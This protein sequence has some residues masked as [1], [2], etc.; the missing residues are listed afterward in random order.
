[1]QLN[2]NDE[3]P[4]PFLDKLNLDKEKVIEAF[5]TPVNL[6]GIAAYVYSSLSSTSN[7]ATEKS[8]LDEMA[9]LYQSVSQAKKESTN[10]HGL[11]YN[12][13]HQE[14]LIEYKAIKS[15][16]DDMTK[17]DAEA[18]IEKHK[19]RSINGDNGVIFQNNDYNI[20]QMASVIADKKFEGIPVL[21]RH[22]ANDHTNDTQHYLTPL[23]VQSKFLTSI[24][25]NIEP[26]TLENFRSS[27]IIKQKTMN[28]SLIK[29]ENEVNEDVKFLREKGHNVLKEDVRSYVEFDR[30]Y[31]ITKNNQSITDSV[32]ISINRQKA[33]KL[34]TVIDNPE[35]LDYVKDIRLSEYK[36]DQVCAHIKSLYKRNDDSL[37]YFMSVNIESHVPYQLASIIKKDKRRN[38][39]DLQESILDESF[40]EPKRQKRFG[41]GR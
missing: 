38:D 20:A 9:S 15:L 36:N 14:S 32:D 6:A 17:S 4:I 39:P 12:H 30:L 10:K 2:R 29:Q 7:N 22:S 16:I 40:F 5:L 18:F 31:R 25:D 28:E 3:H 11:I 34:T 13:A 1:M 41:F 26:S 33:I 21:P 8:Y 35:L 24:F 27:N 23:K 37:D 19:I